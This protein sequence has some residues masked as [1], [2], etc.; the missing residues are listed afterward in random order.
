MNSVNSKFAKNSSIIG[1]E[2][3]IELNTIKKEFQKMFNTNGY[4]NKLYFDIDVWFLNKN[5][6][7]QEFLILA[8][9]NKNKITLNEEKEKRKK[10]IRF[11]NNIDLIESDKSNN[12]EFQ[13][14][15]ISRL[16]GYLSLSNTKKNKLNFNFIKSLNNN[17]TS[18]NKNCNIKFNNKTVSNKNIT[19]FY[20]NSFNNNCENKKKVTL[21]TKYSNNRSEENT[22]SLTSVEDKSSMRE[23]IAN[24][25]LLIIKEFSINENILKFEISKFIDAISKAILKSDI[26]IEKCTSQI[27]QYDIKNKIKTIDIVSGEIGDRIKTYK[28]KNLV[29][30]NKFTSKSTISIALSK[31]DYFPEGDYSFKLYFEELDKEFNIKSYEKKLIANKKIKINNGY[32]QV[33]LFEMNL[34]K[35]DI[36]FPDIHIQPIDHDKLT[37][38]LISNNMNLKTIELVNVYNNNSYLNLDN[39]SPLNFIIEKNKNNYIKNSVSTENLST[40]DNISPI[41]AR[42]IKIED[43]ENLSN[44]SINAKKKEENYICENT[45]SLDSYSKDTTTIQFSNQINNNKKLENN[46]FDY[47]MEKACETAVEDEAIF[48]NNLFTN[49]L[50]KNSRLEKDFNTYNINNNSLN[51]INSTGN[52]E[53]NCVLSNICDLSFNNNNI[54]SNVK[55]INYK[56]DYSKCDY[57]NKLI[58]NDNQIKKSNKNSFSQNYISRSSI[59]KRKN[60]KFKKRRISSQI[61]NKEFCENIKENNFKF[62]DTFNNENYFN[63]LNNNQSTEYISQEKT[64]NSTLN[65]HTHTNCY[66]SN[67]FNNICDENI[68]LLKKSQTESKIKYDN[69]Y[70]TRS[71]NNYVFKNLKNIINKKNNISLEKQ[72]KPLQESLEFKNPA[73]KNTNIFNY[74]SKSNDNPNCPNDFLSDV[75][76]LKTFN[77][78]KAS[79]DLNNEYFNKKKT[80]L[81]QQSYNYSKTYSILK[82]I[83]FNINDSSGCS[84]CKYGIKLSRN[85]LDFADSKENL[86]DFFLVNI[87]EILS[88]PLSEDT[89]ATN[90]SVTL[91]VNNDQIVKTGL[92]HED[93]GV[94]LS[95][96]CNLSLELKKSILLRIRNIFSANVALKDI[97]KNRLNSFEYSFPKIKNVLASIN[98]Y[99]NTNELGKLYCQCC[100]SC[101]IF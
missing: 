23:E 64:F 33:N 44:L 6:S 59:T 54:L 86:L 21:N 65:K 38:H 24:E 71:K 90:Y 27:E 97:H 29:N 83:E 81:S 52:S 32:E 40:F 7:F 26:T 8:G 88:M 66:T 94:D 34:K 70:I 17:I 18:V 39:Q 69:S 55:T 30:S 22:N 99:K 82:S 67:S 48:E 74:F 89:F 78:I 13:N 20:K 87:N 25:L 1:I 84:M 62:S 10:F 61:L 92:P 42:P 11:K 15:I 12:K 51:I 93:I 76:Y 19:Q 98:S 85:G 96:I 43:N 37:D 68:I 47:I 58:N 28:Y 63:K 53:N 77:L 72:I 95:I 31:L 4:T 56:N 100:K 16:V 5:K 46:N 50:T 73:S 2:S 14:L 49:K 80:F 57:N 60:S 36:S 79:N 101:N 75:E 3:E 9:I 35:A 45:S 91:K 41:F